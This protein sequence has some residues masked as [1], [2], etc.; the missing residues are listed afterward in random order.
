[1]SDRRLIPANARVAAAELEGQIQAERYAAGEIR[2]IGG[3]PLS[4][5]WSAPECGHRDRQLL[6]GEHFRV[7]E[8][9]GGFAFGMAQKDG[10]VGYLRAADLCDAIDST[11][12]VC[13]P[14]THAYPAPDMKR[15][16]IMP[17]SFGSRFRVVSGAGGFFE[18]EE[19]YFIPKPHLRPLNRPFQDAATIAQLHFGAP[20]LWGGNSIWGMDCSGLIQ[21][22]LLFS[23]LACPGDTDLQEAALGQPLDDGTPPRRG[24]LYFWKGHVAMAVDGETLIHANA[25]HMAVAYE[26]IAEAIARIAAQGDGAVTSRRR[27]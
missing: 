21:A 13:T 26:P 19:G 10:Y 15:L 4:T 16:E 24:D 12:F 8:I 25:H 11:H 22:A 9:V 6:P 14:A 1:M 17:L 2:Q 3:V 23:G 20:Y 27:L 18:T 5:L 7:L